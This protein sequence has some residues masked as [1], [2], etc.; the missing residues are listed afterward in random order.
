VSLHQEINVEEQVCGRQRAMHQPV[1]SHHEQLEQI[2]A[3]RSG[4]PRA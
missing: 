3:R 1:L 4:E 2:A